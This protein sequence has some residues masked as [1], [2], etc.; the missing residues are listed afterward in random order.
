MSAA[1][2]GATARALR[3][4]S[5]MDAEEQAGRPLQRRAALRPHRALGLAPRQ[6]I[7]AGRLRLR[8]MAG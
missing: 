5:S 4:L 8:S 3:Y 6:E 1:A 7:D 2:T